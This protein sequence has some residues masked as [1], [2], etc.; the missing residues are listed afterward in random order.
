MKFVVICMTLFAILSIQQQRASEER[1]PLS[2]DHGSAPAFSRGLL[3][4][5]NLET[6][7]PETYRPPSDPVPHGSVTLVVTQTPPRVNEITDNKTNASLQSTSPNSVQD[8]VTSD[9][10]GNLTKLEEQK[11][12]DGKVQSDLEL[13]SAKVSE[14][15]L[16]KL[17]EPV[18]FAEEE[19]ECP[20]CLEGVAVISSPFNL[21][22][23]FC[24]NVNL[25]IFMFFLSYF[26]CN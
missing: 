16:Q 15:E 6:S 10:H 1:V 8:T 18:I 24:R 17:E 21:C 4:D 12:L 19:D 3:V 25:T 11:G 2:S 14:I 9:G 7:N 13:D 5:T 22:S 26:V 23:C 20:I